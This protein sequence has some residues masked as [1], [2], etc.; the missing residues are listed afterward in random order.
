MNYFSEGNKFYANKEYS[1]AISFYLQS[2]E[3]NE[4]IDSASYNAGVCYI[5]L[6]DYYNAISMLKNAI[7]CNPLSKYYFNLA[8]CYAMTN[9]LNKAL[10]YFNLA[11]SLDNNDDECKKAI[12]LI[13]SK[14]QKLFN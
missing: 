5:K 7:N 11:W 4:N 14:S 2:I 6:K 12:N 10:I 9:I 8:Y 1:T 13:L 3:A